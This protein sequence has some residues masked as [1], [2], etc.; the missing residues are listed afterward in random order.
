MS[1]VPIIFIPSLFCRCERD[2]RFRFTGDSTLL[3]D[4][5]DGKGS[6]RVEPP[7]RGT[8]Q[9]WLL[10]KVFSKKSILYGE[11]VIAHNFGLFD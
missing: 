6:K 1:A 2:V 3:I 11:L 9:G 10:R 8:A 7:V 5:T 4:Y